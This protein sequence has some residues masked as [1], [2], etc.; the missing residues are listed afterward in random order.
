LIALDL[1][2]RNCLWLLLLLP[3]L[4]AWAGRG[5]R[6]RARQWSLLGQG[7]RLPPDGALGWIAALA[8]LIIAL[9][10][11]RW[12][13]V[14]APP[15]PPGR[16]VVCLVDCSRSMAAR[17]AVPDRLGVAV[18][19]AS[20]LV[21][22]LVREPGSQ[23]AVVAFAG[24]GVLR[25][26][27]TENAGA[28]LDA[29]GALRPGAVRPGGTDLG[30]AL[31]VALDA[32]GSPEREQEQAG[33]RTVVLFSD[34]EDHAGSWPAAIERTRA[35][36]IVVHTVAIGDA[37]SGHPIPIS[38]PGSGAAGTLTYRG[39]PVLSR[40][41]DRELAAIAEAT[42][43]AVVPLGLAATDL[44]DLY[45]KRIEPVAREK[46][47]VFRPYERA[48][49]YG[50]F[51]LAALGLGLASSWPWRGGLGPRPVSVRLVRPAVLVLFFALIAGAARDTGSRNENQ[52]PAMAVDAGCHAY[53]SRRWGEALAHFE[54]AIALDPGAAVPRYDAAATLF[55]MARF[56]EAQ[57]AYT[58]ARRAAGAAL[59]TRI[60]YALGNTALALG[61]VAG[62][63]GHYN[64]C[65]ASR[66]AGSDLEAIRRDAAL[67]RQF[68]LEAARRSPIP[69]AGGDGSLSAPRPGPSPDRGA[70]QDEPGRASAGAGVTDGAEPPGSSR[71]R[72]RGPGGAGGS[73]PAPPQAGSPEAQLARALERVRESRRRRLP[74]TPPP[75]APGD[76]DERKEW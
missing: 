6:V 1:T 22:A 37:G 12:G 21:Q 48:P 28:V 54:H 62:A 3:G 75:D 35:A 56:A 13:R 61:D 64:D 17:D 5:R 38:L 57:A 50:W 18:E 51:V 31:T 33:G 46:R 29:L 42:G 53:E 34:G 23:I 8:C 36:G 7:G 59:R 66:A 55:Q 45:L 41:V 43:G 69:P 67:N 24:R 10:G 73:G 72:R 16:D 49:Q 9:A 60:D 40:R 32:F 4:L 68:A 39:A 47:L 14:L 25:C 70:H 27:L 20:K 26:P 65:L 76:G 74:E 19:S 63:I 44:G 71:S 58:Q 2:Q 15:L 52:T 30:A 11:P